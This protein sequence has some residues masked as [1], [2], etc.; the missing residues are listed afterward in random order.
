MYLLAKAGPFYLQLLTYP[1]DYVLVY[2]RALSHA[3]LIGF[4][5]SVCVC[6][7]M[8]SVMTDKELDAASTARSVK[9]KTKVKTSK[10]SNKMKNQVKQLFELAAEM[11]ESQETLMDRI[12]KPEQSE[13]E[14]GIVREVKLT[15]LIQTRV[16]VK[17]I[18]LGS[19]PRQ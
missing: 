15:R 17:K 12:A 14:E 7:S 16:V 2:V 8:F 18:L 3:S 9:G 1:S 10:I 19:L 6:S 11:K 5:P 4:V 13:A